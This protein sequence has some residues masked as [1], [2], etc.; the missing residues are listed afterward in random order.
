[1]N[2]ALTSLSGL[3]GIQ[4]ELLLFF[5]MGAGILAAVLGVAGAMAGPRAELQRMRGGTSSGA[6][7]EQSLISSDGTPQG[8][9]K[10]FVP[11]SEKERFQIALKMRQAGI[12]H[13]NAI[14]NYYAVRGLLGI[15]LPSLV[16]ALLFLP[17]DIPLRPQ[18][19]LLE[20]LGTMTTVMVLVGLLA[21]GFY[22]PA[23]WL[24]NRITA[25]RKQIEQGLPNALDLLK[26]SV[27]AGMGF[28]A[29]MNRVASEMAKVVPPI[30]QEFASV[31]LEIQAG[32]DR[33][34]AFMNMAQRSGVEE[35]SAF[36]NVILQSA[37]FGSSISGA[38]TTY[39]EEM[40]TTRELKA[41]EMANKL[42]VK[43]S[44]LMALM[45]MPVLLM[46]T[47]TPVVI[48]MIGTFSGS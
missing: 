28:D 20:G 26:I 29:A 43:M 45:M 25:R 4:P 35:M 44:G 37:R 42:P 36:V 22:S 27:E 14:R 6:P 32:M 24:K 18:I 38:L 12:F 1:M 31:Q 2:G 9:L 40:R 16:V 3:T 7:D 39:A 33:E 13:R 21:A 46:I 47:L 10:A 41:Q 30:S 48:R 19:T 34:R 5:L 15:V 8:I 11:G 23:L 17:K